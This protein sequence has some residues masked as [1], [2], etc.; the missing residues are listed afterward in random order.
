MRRL[1]K[2]SLSATG[3]V[4]QTDRSKISKPLEPATFCSEHIR[5]DALESSTS[6][7]DTA[8]FDSTYSTSAEKPLSHCDVQSQHTV[9]SNC[10]TLSSFF[11]LTDCE[12]DDTLCPRH[13]IPLHPFRKY[14]SCPTNHGRSR[15][16]RSS[17]SS[18]PAT[19]RFVLPRHRSPQ[20]RT[21]VPA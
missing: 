18:P 17:A 1:S 7:F 21:C 4:I 15:T 13:R 2:E 11:C 8:I 16:I 19:R 5:A 14:C 20:I 3:L 10:Y 12:K 6:I 9:H